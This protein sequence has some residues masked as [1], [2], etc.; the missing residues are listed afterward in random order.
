[1]LW[2]VNLHAHYSEPDPTGDFVLLV[3]WETF[4]KALLREFPETEAILTPGW[5]PRYE[6]KQWRAFLADRGY[7]PYKENTHRKIV[8]SS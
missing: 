8:K 4:E 7:M 1:M 5:E 6:P 3:L 2:E